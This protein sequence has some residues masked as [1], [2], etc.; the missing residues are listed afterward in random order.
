MRPPKKGPTGSGV[1]GPLI[2]T[3]T[4]ATDSPPTV[5]PVT[6]NVGLGGPAKT[7]LVKQIIAVPHQM[8]DPH[9]RPRAF[10]GHG[11]GFDFA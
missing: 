11:I 9:P 5:V 10:S 8:W 1:D 7:T 6:L 2:K 3:V 4:A